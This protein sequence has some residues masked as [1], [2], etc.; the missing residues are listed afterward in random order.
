MF[1]SVEE[2]ITLPVVQ[3]GFG[4]MDDFIAFAQTTLQRRRV[5]SGRSLELHTRQIFVEEGLVEDRDF[6]H[7]GIS[8]A[9]K[10]PDFLSPPKPATTIPTTPKSDLGC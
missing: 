10:R 3:H 1:Q 7:D 2:A 5:R 4:S 8:E 9:G 6:T